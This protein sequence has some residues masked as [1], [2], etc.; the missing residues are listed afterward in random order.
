MLRVAFSSQNPT[1][2]SDTYSQVSLRCV[3]FLLGFATLVLSTEKYKKV[4]KKL[5]AIKISL[6]TAVQF[7]IRKYDARF[8]TAGEEDWEPRVGFNVSLRT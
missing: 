2:R 5:I 7:Q 4:F 3:V 6:F 1:P 8:W